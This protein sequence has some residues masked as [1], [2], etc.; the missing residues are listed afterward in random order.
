MYTNIF[1]ENYRLRMGA[2]DLLILEC[3]AFQSES[4]HRITG[5][6][7]HQCGRSIPRVMEAKNFQDAWSTAVE[8]RFQGRFRLKPAPMG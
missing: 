6:I 5:R 3:K 2:T 1:H 8:A 4:V 7:V